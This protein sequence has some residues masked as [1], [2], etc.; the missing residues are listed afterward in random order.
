MNTGDKKEWSNKPDINGA[1]ESRI[2]LRY[3]AKEALALEVGDLD[4]ADQR[5]IGACLRS[6]GWQRAFK[7]DGDEVHRYWIHPDKVPF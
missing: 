4:V 3:I 5:R 2:T 6:M 1:L 7:R